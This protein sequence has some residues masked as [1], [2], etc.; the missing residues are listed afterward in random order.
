MVSMTHKARVA[1]LLLF[2]LTLAPTASAEWKEKVLYSFQGGTDGSVPAGGVVFDKQGNLY[3]LT[4]YGGST[5]CP[6]GWCGTFYQLSPPPQEGGN[7]TE[8]VLYV[9]KGHNQ[10]DG[11][12]P[13]GSLIADDSGNFY[14]VTGYGGSGPC[15]LFGTATGCGTVFELNPPKTKGGKWTEKVL[16]NF[17]GGNDGDLP[18]GPLVFDS[19]GNLYGATEFGG[20]KGTTC[21]VFYGGTCGTVFKL[22][23]P[24]TKG[25]KWTERVLHSFA[26]GT[27]GAVP[28]GA[29][30]LDSQGAA[31]GTTLTGGNQGCKNSSGI[32]CGTAYELMPPANGQS[33]RREM[34]LH[35]FTGKADGGS[36]LAGLT[37]GKNSDLS[38]TAGGGGSQG[39]GVVFQLAAHSGGRWIESVLHN[40]TDNIHGR[41]PASPLAFD[42][43]GNLCGSA[44]G[45]EHFRG[46]LFRLSAR[47]GGGWVFSDTYSFAGPPDGSYPSASIIHQLG[48][49]YSTT[50]GGG[51]GQECQ[52]GCGTVF[53]ST[54]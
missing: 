13:S 48:R 6:P 53:E 5:A 9:F 18:T 37:L 23:P 14:G 47:T 50:Q 12:S 25:G 35:R 42:G 2:I 29:L 7:W 51:T 32:G 10:N 34:M 43:L 27:D 31:Y 41:G 30:V 33:M 16:Y 45:G 46:V 1:P 3:G 36:P 8:T 28:N 22:S 26:G 38:G 21:D 19:A 24:K 15:V 17:Q 20:G 52:G 44:L 40:F 11:S 49:I 39:L 54:P 4:I